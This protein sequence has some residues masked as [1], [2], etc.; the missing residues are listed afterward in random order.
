MI[1]KSLPSKVSIF[2]VED[3]DRVVES[4]HPAYQAEGDPQFYQYHPHSALGLGRGFDP[5]DITEQKRPGISHSVVQIDA[6]SPSSELT[7]MYVRS[8]EEL[9]FSIKLDGKMEGSYLAYKG[10][11]SYSFE[12]ESNFSQ[13]SVSVVLT[14]SADYGRWGM[15]ADA[16]LIEDAKNELGNGE[17]FA[18][19]FGTRYVAV[20]RRGAS[21]AVLIRIEAVDMSTKFSFTSEFSGSGGWGPLSATAKQK[22]STMLRLAA[23]HSRLE[24]YVKATGGPGLSALGATMKGYAASEPDPLAKIQDALS[25][26]LSEFNKDN[27]STVEYAVAPMSHFGWDPDA[28]DP[29]NDLKETKLRALAKE[30]RSARDQLAVIEGYQAGTHLLAILYPG[31][32]DG[33]LDRKPELEGFQEAV[34]ER[35]KTCR[36]N[37]DSLGGCEMPQG[38]IVIVSPEVLELIGPP[39]IYWFISG[40]TENVGGYSLDDPIKCRIIMARPRGSR[41]AVLKEF[42]PDAKDMYVFLKVEGSRLLLYRIVA[43][44]SDGTKTP[45]GENVVWGSISVHWST[46]GRPNKGEEYEDVTLSWMGKHQGEFSCMDAIE[47]TD[48]ANRQFLV[49][50]L[51]MT[52]QGDGQ[53]NLLKSELNFL[54]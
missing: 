32:L 8:Q 14:A 29:W 12:N 7:A 20:E 47:V 26:A 48:R 38:R 36:S 50:Y 52:W 45:S 13:S 49:G 6:G 9:N 33:V 4:A 5:R 35:H 24:I 34:A 10:E 28:I 23:K 17:R 54:V 1:R 43:T 37:V 19:L 22:F 18:A 15:A 39:R 2:S 42:V 3:I 21:I 46:E 40:R 44:Y 53:G 41:L 11:G 25:T 27:A 51:E 16:K 30:Y 31:I